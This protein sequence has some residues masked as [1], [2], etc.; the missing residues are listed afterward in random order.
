MVVMKPR[1]SIDIGKLKCDFP[2]VYEQVKKLGK[3]TAYP[4]FG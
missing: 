3:P 1:E 2:E 4:K